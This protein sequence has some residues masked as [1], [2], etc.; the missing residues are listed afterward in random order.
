MQSSGSAK[1]PSLGQ[2]KG[3][4]FAIRPKVVVVKIKQI[5]AKMMGKFT[6]FSRIK[7]CLLINSNSSGWVPNG[8]MLKISIS[9]TSAHNS[10]YQRF[11]MVC[12]T[13]HSGRKGI[14]DY[15]QF[16]FL[17]ARSM[18]LNITRSMRSNEV[19][20][21]EFQGRKMNF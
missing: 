10:S 13:L 2:T 17:V 3:L 18:H 7:L 16:C 11:L 4:S 20:I 15:F 8:S 21:V 1:C 12:L 14:F 5:S 6:I 19:E 9:D